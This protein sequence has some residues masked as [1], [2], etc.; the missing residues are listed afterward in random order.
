[1][2][3]EG[4]RKSLTTNTFIWIEGNV[5]L[6]QF[7]GLNREEETEKRTISKELRC[8]AEMVQKERNYITNWCS[9]DSYSNIFLK[10]KKMVD[11][12]YCKRL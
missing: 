7:L 8:L 11:I 4:N 5:W 10:K 3:A 12:G 6:E 1:M 9:L 2:L